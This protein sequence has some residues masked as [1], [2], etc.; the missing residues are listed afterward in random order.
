MK[1]RQPSTF[2]RND[3]CVRARQH[4]HIRRVALTVGRRVTLTAF[5]MTLDF[6]SPP[7]GKWR[8]PYA[9]ALS[10]VLLGERGRDRASRWASGQPTGHGEHR[11]LPHPVQ[12]A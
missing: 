1:C 11:R 7:P 10:G 3:D 4:Y 8:P 2:L 6:F 5:Y 9:T 12:P